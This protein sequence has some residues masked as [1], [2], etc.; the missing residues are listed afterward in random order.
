MPEVKR[1]SLL[2]H[3]GFNI[4][5]LSVFYLDEKK[6]DLKHSFYGYQNTSPVTRRCKTLEEKFE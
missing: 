1:Y 3:L 6:E 4:G 5:D 2:E